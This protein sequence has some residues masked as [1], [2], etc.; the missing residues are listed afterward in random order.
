[1]V[2]VRQSFYVTYFKWKVSPH[3]GLGAM[4]CVALVQIGQVCGVRKWI[5]AGA[6]IQDFLAG[7][8]VKGDILPL[9]SMKPISFRAMP[10]LEGRD[11]HPF[12]WFDQAS[13]LIAKNPE[14][15]VPVRG[16]FNLAQMDTNRFIR[17]EDSTKNP[18][19]SIKQK[20]AEFSND[21]GSKLHDGQSNFEPGGMI[22]GRNW[23]PC[24]YLLVTKTMA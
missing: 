20:Q 11:Q 1:M 18:C 13:R 22:I 19:D 3:Q 12:F 16:Q 15:F 14:P 7:L 10:F 8:D 24:S 9:I 21:A 6:D 23:E 4:G 17:L 2:L 5:L